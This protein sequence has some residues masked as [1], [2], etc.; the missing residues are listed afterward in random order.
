MAKAAR[1]HVPE[2][3]KG[4]KKRKQEENGDERGKKKALAK[5]KGGAEAPGDITLGEREERA[6]ENLF[7]YIE[8]QGGDRRAVENF[9]CRVSRKP[10]DGR[11]DTNYYNEQGRRFRSMVE[12]GKFFQFGGCSCQISRR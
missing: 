8:E 3:G 2:E 9:R 6:M 12:V 1:D 11:Y 10:S 4:S 5:S 7:A